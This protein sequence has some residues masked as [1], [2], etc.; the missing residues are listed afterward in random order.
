MKASRQSHHHS[1]PRCDAGLLPE[2]STLNIH[3]NQLP[4][5][6][7]AVSPFLPGESLHLDFTGDLAQPAINGVTTGLTITDDCSGAR[8]CLHHS[9]TSAAS[10]IKSL[11]LFS[12]QSQVPIKVIRVDQQFV[13]E[14]LSSH[15]AAHSIKIEASPPRDHSANGRSE[16]TVKVIKE[17]GRCLLQTGGASTFLLPLA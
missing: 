11:Q 9:S 4:A 10:I 14:A 15:A 8:F 13:N 6:S 2:T 1:H 3:L 7:I 5:R 12:A 17:K 16:T